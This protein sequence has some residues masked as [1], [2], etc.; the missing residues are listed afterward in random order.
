MK[1]MLSR[2]GCCESEKAP[3]YPNTQNGLN[4]DQ[5]YRMV[6]WSVKKDI[7]RKCHI[8]KQYYVNRLYFMSEL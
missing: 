8:F 2:I 1:F 4:S 7:Q 5:V 3:H 6:L